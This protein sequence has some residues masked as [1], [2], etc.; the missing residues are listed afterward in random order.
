[1]AWSTIALAAWLRDA[2]LLREGMQLT[3]A[4]AEERAA[5]IAMQLGEVLA[6]TRCRCGRRGTVNGDLCSDCYL[7]EEWPGESPS[8]EATEV[9][10]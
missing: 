9:I 8:A 3:R 1:M 10:R 4:L 6:Q 5:N 2:L 7:G